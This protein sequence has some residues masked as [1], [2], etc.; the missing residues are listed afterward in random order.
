MLPL[1]CVFTLNNTPHVPRDTG[2]NA[3]EPTGHT[4]ASSMVSQ[5]LMACRSGHPLVLW[6][7]VCVGF[8]FVANSA[9]DVLSARLF[10]RC[11]FV[12][13]IVCVCIRVVVDCDSNIRF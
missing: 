4:G 5:Y 9:C 11:I 8:A 3:E 1:S 10:Y 6:V 13:L 12:L 7:F 2:G